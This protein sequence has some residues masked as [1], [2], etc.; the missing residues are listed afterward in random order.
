M[1]RPTRFRAPAAALALVLA[2][3]WP[4]RAAPAAAPVWTVDPAA[5][6]LVYVGTQGGTPFEG[7]FERFAA[8]I[9][10]DPGDPATQRIDIVIDMASANSG[11]RDRDQTVKDG[12]WF[13]VAQHPQGRFT[14]TR[15][16]AEAAGRYR[17]E[18][19]LTIRDVT[20]A[21]VLPFTL[22]VE[23]GVARAAGEVTIDRVDYGVGRGPWAA[24]DMVGRAVTI[25]FDL[26]ARRDR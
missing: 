13:A 26:T 22:S 11:S 17:A 1:A 19:D 21:V 20:R 3:A 12:D 24:G 18:A 14:V 15:V 2:L 23:D 8:S 5:S 4:G 6:R 9:R 7:R 25:R 10:F 16:V